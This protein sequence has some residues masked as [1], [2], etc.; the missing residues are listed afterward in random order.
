MK[1]WSTNTK[2]LRKDKDKFAIWKLEQLINFGLGGERLGI[3]ELKKYW[4]VI[5]IDPFKRRFLAL[6]VN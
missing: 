4:S 2:E 3:N 5:D 6:F 1:N